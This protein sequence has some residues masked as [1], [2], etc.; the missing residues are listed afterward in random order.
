VLL[1]RCCLRHL[2]WCCA[3]PIAHQIHSKNRL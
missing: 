3:C 2:P 1:L